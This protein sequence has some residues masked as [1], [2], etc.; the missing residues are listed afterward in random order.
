MTLTDNS[1]RI[2]MMKTEVC[3][4]PGF[5]FNVKLLSDSVPIDSNGFDDES[6]FSL[7]LSPPLFLSHTSTHRDKNTHQFQDSCICSL[8]EIFFPFLGWIV[9]GNTNMKD[10]GVPFSTC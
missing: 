4:I 2:K 6:F 7:S 3:E 9:E 5:G 8:A 10:F 1:S